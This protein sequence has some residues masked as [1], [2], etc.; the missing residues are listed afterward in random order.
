KGEGAALA[1]T[2]EPVRE[3]SSAARMEIN[4]AY[5]LIR[6]ALEQHGLYKAGLKQDT[7]VLTFISPQVGERHREVI[8]GLAQETGYPIS[9]HPHP[10]QQQILQYASQVIREA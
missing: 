2:V 1:E 3:N 7:I 9:I 4:E 5:G 6:G 10:N 8:R